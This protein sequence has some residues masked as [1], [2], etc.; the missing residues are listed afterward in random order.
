MS[1]SLTDTETC[2]ANIKRELLPIVYGCEKFHTYLYGRTFTVETDHKPLEMISMKNLIA[3]PA[4]L[5]RMLLWLQQ[6]DM[7]IT[8]RPGK[9]MLLADALSHLPSRT[10]TQIQLNLRVDAISMSAFTRSCLTK[11]AAETQ[12]DPILST[13]HRLTQN[14]WPDRCTNIPRITKNYW[15]FRDELSIEDDLLMKGEW[16]VIPQ[17]CRDSITVDLHKSHAGINKALALARTCVY[18]PRMEADVPLWCPTMA[19]HLMEMNSK[20]LLMKFDFMHTTS[21][22]HFHWSNGSSRP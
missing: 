5:Q 12:W 6:Y 22:P 21:S 4:R 18:W 7:I 10:D 2:Y 11:V 9:E 16:V 19:L 15:Y 17:S 8:Y 13:V 1:K 3:A 20:G 14:G